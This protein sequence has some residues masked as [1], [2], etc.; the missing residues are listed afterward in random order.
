[1]VGVNLESRLR[2]STWAVLSAAV[3]LHTMLDVQLCDLQQ[4]SGDESIS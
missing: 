4:E 1:M 3:A 2:Y